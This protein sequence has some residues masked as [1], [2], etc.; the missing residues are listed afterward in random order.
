MSSRLRRSPE[1][2]A[3][4]RAAMVGLAIQSNS[5]FILDEREIRRPGVSYSVESLREL[6]QELGKDVAL[7]FC[8]RSRRVHESCRLAQLA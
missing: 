7:L 8:Y 3:E 2:I 4:A 1:R 5:R 6:K